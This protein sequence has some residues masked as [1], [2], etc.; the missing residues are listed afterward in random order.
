MPEAKRLLA[1]ID[2][3]RLRLDPGEKAEVAFALAA[4]SE[5]ERRLGFV[6]R[7]RGYYEFLSGKE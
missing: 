4:E 1:T 7:M 3:Q 2:G 6:L 5:K